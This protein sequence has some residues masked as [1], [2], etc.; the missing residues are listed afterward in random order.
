MRKQNG[1]MLYIFEFSDHL[2]QLKSLSKF[3]TEEQ[4][5]HRCFVRYHKI[6]HDEELSTEIKF[7][8]TFMLYIS[9][10]KT[11]LKNHY[12]LVHTAPEYQT[13]IEK[14]FFYF[15]VK[16]FSN[17]RTTIII[18]DLRTNR[19]NY[20]LQL[21]CKKL[22]ENERLAKRYKEKVDG[23]L[24]PSIYPKLSRCNFVAENMDIIVGIPG[25]FNPSRRNY[26]RLEEIDIELRKHFNPKY[27]I[28]GS[29][30][31]IPRS[32]SEKLDICTF[33]SD[34][35]FISD[36]IYDQRLASVDVLL[37][38]NN[39]NDYECK[40]TGII[41]DAFEYCLPI[42]SLEKSFCEASDEYM[43]PISRADEL[44]S[45]DSI[46]WQSSLIDYFRFV[47]KDIIY[48]EY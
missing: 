47:V 39:F 11:L 2:R 18:R 32:L 46:S 19:G 7:N 20:L 43:L 24:Y 25:G 16:L 44:T 37:L 36:E 33:K 41:G 28:L 9:L 34:E 13:S 30:I 21:N 12:I 5:E 35:K 40:G 22:V 15:I 45:L 17:N 48:D 1:K 27:F 10:M 42:L 4:I 38:L 23:F 14:K 31:G 26:S 8:N 3:M 29:N 6:F